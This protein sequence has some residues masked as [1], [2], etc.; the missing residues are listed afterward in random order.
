MCHW[1]SPT[2]FQLLWVWVG[3]VSTL[4]NS[5]GGLC[6]EEELTH[7]LAEFPKSY[8]WWGGFAATHV[9]PLFEGETHYSVTGLL[10]SSVWVSGYW[11]FH[12]PTSVFQVV[13]GI[14]V[15]P[16]A[17]AEVF[18]V[19]GNGDLC[20]LCSEVSWVE[21]EWQ[22]MIQQP[23]SS[24]W[25]KGRLFWLSAGFS[26]YWG[27]RGGAAKNPVVAK[28]LGWRRRCCQW[29]HSCRGLQSR[30]RG[31]AADLVAAEVSGDG[32]GCAVNYPASS[33]VSGVEGKM[34][35]WSCQLQGSPWW[36]EKYCWW[37]CWL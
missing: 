31:A 22:P 2:P 15:G 12:Q 35:T 17:A 6:V 29:S 21:P 34:L 16:L 18:G 13:D 10:C 24:L 9:D 8:S 27:R 25:W 28:V 1:G 26:G 11:S 33:E 19:K 4:L 30:G 36:K 20:S 23:P 32:R 14:S 5:P 3:L 37:Y 7:T